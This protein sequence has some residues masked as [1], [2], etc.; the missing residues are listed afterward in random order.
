MIVIESALEGGTFEAG[1]NA[2]KLGE[3]LFC[4]EYAEPSPSAA[5]NAY[6]LQQGAFSL[7]RTRTGQANL[8]KLISVVRSGATSVLQ[9]QDQKEL[10]LR[11]EPNP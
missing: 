5:G 1:K 10:L 3:P 2:L 8:S 6:F 9:P 11:E 7:K 4:V